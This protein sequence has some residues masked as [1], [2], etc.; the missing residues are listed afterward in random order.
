MEPLK[1]TSLSRSF[2]GVAAVRD[3]SLTVKDRELLSVIGPNGAGKTTLLKLITGQIPPDTGKIELFGRDVT[4]VP[5]YARAQMGIALTH[6][7]VRP[8]RGMTL[9]E[10]V[11][12]A[13]GHGHFNRPVSSLFHRPAA[14]D[15]ARARELLD[16]VGIG[17]AADRSASEVPLGY[18]KRM[19][20]A[21]VLA[22]DPKLLLLDEPLAGLNYSEAGQIADLIV[23]LNEG[24]RTVVLIEHNLGEVLRISHRVAVLDNGALLAEGLPAEVIARPDVRA[25]YLGKEAG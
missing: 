4:A 5:Q 25:A 19:Q 7:I 22:T 11:T 20:I 17:Q 18:L 9:G 6:Q 10:N 12:A 13:M 24:G 2:G 14:A 8:F 3:V 21:R 23:R 15:A 1:T 16:L